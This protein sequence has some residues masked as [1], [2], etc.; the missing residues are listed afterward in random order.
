MSQTDTSL[1]E[2]AD[3]LYAL[4]LADFTPARDAAAKNLGKAS[5]SDRELVARLK[6]LKK[7]TL[8]AWV[9][10]HFVRRDAQQ[11]AEI[12]TIAEGLRAAQK[13]MDGDEL[14]QLTRQ[15]RQLTA[16]VTTRARSLAMDYG[17]RVTDAV[18]EQVEATITAAIL[19]EQ[20]AS[21]LRTGMLVRSLS[22]VGFAESDAAAVA[23]PEAL[24][25]LP[26]AT[27]PEPPRPELRV[28]P[29]LDAGKVAREAK[30]SALVDAQEAVNRAREQH[31]AALARHAKLQ[32]KSLQNEARLDELRRRLAEVELAQERLDDDLA[33][34]DET[35]ADAA[36]HVVSAEGDR[37][38]AARALAEL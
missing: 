33:E 6:G 28:V 37:D 4:P 12:L 27:P 20:A 36:S 1:V 30:E 10:N 26:T 9:V 21:A 2:L 35:L 22:S 16:A 17:V 31:T 3:E 19:D 5:D 8:A 38:Q 32:A 11:V 23:L 18:S 13:A 34:A 29:D 15:R 7:P 25:K 24:G 14:R